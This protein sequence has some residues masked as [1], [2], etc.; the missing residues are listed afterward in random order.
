ML[1]LSRNIGEAIVINDETRITLLS[2]NGQQV[3][4]G[5]EAPS[6]VII[7]REEIQQRIT[8]QTSHTKTLSPGVA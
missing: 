7:H 5:F 2:I 3:R 4:L 6:E 8:R 1:V